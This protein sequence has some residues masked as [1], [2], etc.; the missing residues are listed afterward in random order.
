MK[1]PTIHPTAWIAQGAVV[2]GDVTLKE[3]ANIWYN[4]VV[5]GDTAPIVIGENTNVQDCAVLHVDENCP[6]ILGDNVTVGHGA[7]LHGCNV[8][9]QA[10]IGMGAI[11]L[12]GAVIGAGSI[13]GAG[14]LVTAG[15]VLP[16]NSLA[17]G[18]PAKVVRQV[19][20]EERE[21]TVKNALQY[22]K[23]SKE[24]QAEE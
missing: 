6:L 2:K 19:R 22:V 18:S 3:N 15:T 20:P 1:Q 23:E 21:S 24:Y 10:L 7:I 8:E 5:R 4:A 12:N 14:A 9:D 17:V 13:I 11:V 16:E